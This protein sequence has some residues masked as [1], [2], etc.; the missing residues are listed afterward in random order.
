[1]NK[2]PEF[3][4]GLKLA[5]GFFH[6]IVR[7]ILKSHYPDLQYSA[8][9]IGHGSEVLEFDDE[10][11]TDHSWGPRLIL[12]LSTGDLNSKRDAVHSI[13]SRELPPTFM[14][15][16]TNFSEPDPLD[17]G[18]QVMR[19]STSDSINHRI[20]IYTLENYIAGYMNI[21]IRKE[22]SPVDWLTIPQ[23]K[24]RS[25]TAGRV[26]Q[27]RLG[28]ENIRTRLQWYPNDVWL[29]ILASAWMRISQ[30]EHLMG[31]AGMTGDKVGSAIIGSRLV[32]DIIRLCF[33]MEKKYMPYAKWFGTAF[34]QLQ[35][36]EKLA[37]ALKNALQAKSW[38]KRE[39]SLCLA[40]EILAEM[41]NSLKITKPVPPKVHQFFG[42]PFKIIGGEKFAN[43]LVKQ[44]ND[45]EIIPLTKRSL[46]GN[47]DLISDNTDVLE[48]ASL[49]LAL[50]ALY[51]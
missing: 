19:P 49:R 41:N 40:Y 27:D 17:H 35:S 15:Y 29:Y 39:E 33:L 8:A 18:V 31:R 48:D 28:L 26:F 37:P 45:P 6:E 21:D 50:K 25:V 51:K 32:R 3:I 46:I 42:R 11:S 9:L 38:Q 1:M 2:R 14:G 43:A 47:I 36:A 34:D 13:L 12:F 16:P 23:Q 5:E 10:M 44:I 30:E 20:E 4:R 22:L 24:L 7:P